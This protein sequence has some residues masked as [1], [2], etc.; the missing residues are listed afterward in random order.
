ML[1]LG[2]SRLSTGPTGEKSP[3]CIQVVVRSSMPE[4]TDSPVRRGEFPERE[5]AGKAE[6]VAPRSAPSK[7]TAGS[8][9]CA[10]ES[11]GVS[12]VEE[13]TSPRGRLAALAAPAWIG[14]S[15]GERADSAAPAIATVADA[16]FA[17]LV[18]ALP[19]FEDARS[20]SRRRP[21]SAAARRTKSESQAM[22]PGTKEC[23]SGVTRRPRRS[24]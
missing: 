13:W 9:E 5:A 12:L 8:R 23:P 7:T 21:E 4:S 2:P 11:A 24:L 14:D 22:S 10:R 19:S 1:L 15:P 17:P 3:E 6:G 18:T 16:P 20:L